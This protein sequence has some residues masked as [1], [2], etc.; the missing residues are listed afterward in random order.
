M[1]L[2]LGMTSGSLIAVPILAQCDVLG[3]EIESTIQAVV[4]EV[5]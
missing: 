3:Q 4:Q 2:R 5:S 1:G